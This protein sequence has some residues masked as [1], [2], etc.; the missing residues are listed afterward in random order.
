MGNMQASQ[1]YL[2]AAWYLFRD[3]CPEMT[4]I[5]INKILARGDIDEVESYIHLDDL[6][7][8]GVEGMKSLLEKDGI[9]VPDNLLEILLFSES[10]RK[11]V[12]DFTFVLKQHGYSE[13]DSKQPN[14]ARHRVAEIAIQ[15][16]RE[17]HN[18]WIKLN[19]KAFFDLC[20]KA[21][22]Y[23]FMPFE[24]IGSEAALRY[25]AV[26]DEIAMVLGLKVHTEQLRSLYWQMQREFCNKNALY[27]NGDLP[28]FL[29]R[30]DYYSS[31]P[32]VRDAIRRNPRIAIQMAYS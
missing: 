15:V 26:F 16:L 18:E 11:D 2:N 14:Y 22:R 23:R 5:E 19:S 30:T 9:I 1:T 27:A 7:R 25:R 10:P 8:V 3:E 28:D 32:D 13:P 24:L 31:V 20:R 17:M 29:R 21:Q 6:F 12:E 4:K